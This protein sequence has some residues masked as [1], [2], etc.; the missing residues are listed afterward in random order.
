VAGD[1]S[2]NHL[3]EPA[4]FLRTFYWLIDLN[5]PVMPFEYQQ[6]DPITVAAESAVVGVQRERRSIQ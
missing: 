1:L 2:I 3:I 5:F 6:T 4:A